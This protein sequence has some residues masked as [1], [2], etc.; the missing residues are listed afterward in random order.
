MDDCGIE[1][2]SSTEPKTTK[3]KKRQICLLEIDAAIYVNHIDECSGKKTTKICPSC[4]KNIEENEYL[5][6]LNDCTNI[7]KSKPLK[8]KLCQT[9]DQKI[10][11]NEYADHMDTCGEQPRAETLKTKKCQNCKQDVLERDYPDHIEQCPDTKPDPNP[12][13]ECPLCSKQFPMTELT[14]HA[15]RCNGPSVIL[16]ST[17]AVPKTSSQTCTTW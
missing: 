4:S 13:G 7:P 11:E 16:K 2:S 14:E 15:G 17:S 10:P 5:D 8:M 6:H 12:T 9:C 3:K 1:S